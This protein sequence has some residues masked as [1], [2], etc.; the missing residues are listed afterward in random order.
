MVGQESQRSLAPF[1]QNADV[2]SEQSDAE[3]MDVSWVSRCVQPRH[4]VVPRY[5]SA[6]WL[7]LM[8]EGRQ[9]ALGPTSNKRKP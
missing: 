7:S 9:R 5:Q 1:L 6:Q 2:T 3:A 4:L 8:S